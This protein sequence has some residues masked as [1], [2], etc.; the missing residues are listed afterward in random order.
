MGTREIDLEKPGLVL[1]LA[2]QHR[3]RVVPRPVVFVKSIR[4]GGRLADVLG[5]LVLD[6]RVVDGP[7]VDGA[8]IV[9][10]YSLLGQIHSVRLVW[11]R[12]RVDDVKLATS[13]GQQK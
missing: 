11:F 5:V 2:L 3:Q 13:S 1:G 12:V 4:V 10:R 7:G 9:Q 8:S 6:A